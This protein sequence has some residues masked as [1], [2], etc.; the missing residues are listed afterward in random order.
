MPTPVLRFF[1]DLQRRCLMFPHIQIF[2]RQTVRGKARLTLNIVLLFAAT[3]FFVLSMNLYHNSKSNLQAV[4]NTYTSIAT[5]EF[6]GYVNTAGNLVSPGDESCVGRHWMSV[7]EFDLSALSALDCVKRIDLRTRVGAYIPGHIQV[8]DITD[9]LPLFYAPGYVMLMGTQNVI[10]FT[11]DAEE[12]FV[13]SFLEDGWQYLELPIRILEDSNPLLEYPDAVT[14]RIAEAE[15]FS[16]E[17]VQAD[18]R[19]LNRSDV[20][21]SVTLYPGVEYVLTGNGGSVWK[22]DPETGVYT[23]Y[24]EYSPYSRPEKNH[25][26]IGLMLSGFSNYYEEYRF[27][28]TKSSGFYPFIPDTYVDTGRFS[29]QRYDDIQNDAGWAEYIRASEYTGNSFAVTLT[30]DISLVP[31]WYEGAMYLN[32]G[33]M[34]TAEEY[35]SG[36][37]VCMVSAQQAAYQGW[38]VGDTLEMHLY[39]CDR[40]FDNEPSS[41]SQLLPQNYL[42]SPEYRKSCGGFFEE[43]TYEIVGIFGQKEFAGYS[44]TAPEVYYNPWNVIYVPANAAPN[45]P[46][47]PIQPSLITVHLQ[48]GSIGAFKQ[49]VEKMGLTDFQV[50][51]YEIIFNYFDQGYS[52]IK[53]SLDEMNHNAI[54]L[55]S[56]SVVLLLTTV[57]LLAFLFSQ[58]YKHSVGILRML[59]GSKK[60]AFAAVLLCAAAVVLTG[61]ILGAA[62]GGGLTQSV[63]ASTAD[64]AMASA[65][66]ALST[67]ASWGVTFLSSVGC[68]ALFLLLTAIFTA[69]YMGKE[70]RA[71]LPQ[72]KA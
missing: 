39:A 18:I 63:G 66:V 45:A 23:W 56:L 19:R 33:R 40:F 15:R 48:N 72:S 59:G 26:G 52:K 14:L 51:E 65:K 11:L 6:Y 29:L 10:R 64:A 61:S 46:E 1:A 49:A 8:M 42:P 38:K 47:G 41:N 37:K 69:T 67:G 17:Q 25:N 58:H 16:A 50:G 7:K 70:P 44:E 13:F 55:L 12:P 24:S 34:I 3:A 20:T 62:I 27:E 28:Y 5:M 32:E 21:D 4:E 68:V 53:P 36:A 22:K 57:I 54:L 9:R 43:D 31:A 60:Q 30:E 71:L 2:L 35:A